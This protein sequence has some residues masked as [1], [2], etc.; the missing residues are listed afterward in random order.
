MIFLSR[1]LDSGEDSLGRPRLNPVSG[2]HYISNRD[3]YSIP[4]ILSPVCGRLTYRVFEACLEMLFE[5]FIWLGCTSGALRFGS[6]CL[7]TGSWPRVWPLSP[8][9]VHGVLYRNLR[10]SSGGLGACG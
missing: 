3:L 7:Q 5:G 1:L 2:V 4:L 8:I 6:D 10:S 9:L